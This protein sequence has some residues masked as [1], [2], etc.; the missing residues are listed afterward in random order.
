[1]QPTN[2]ALGVQEADEPFIWKSFKHTEQI[3]QAKMRQNNRA[4]SHPLGCPELT[5]I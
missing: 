2:I 1:M 3:K 4:N 5:N